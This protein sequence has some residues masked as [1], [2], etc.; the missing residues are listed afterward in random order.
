MSEYIVIFSPELS[1]QP[2]EFATFWNSQPQLQ[3][4]AVVQ[5]QNSQAIATYDMPSW[6][7]GA[8]L[9]IGGMTADIAKDVIT[10][11]LKE[12][13]QSS[14]QRQ[15]EFSVIEKIEDGKTLIIVLPKEEN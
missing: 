14:G 9:F 3:Q 5:V 4:Q 8:L 2:D 1:I 11:V 13:I 6:V 7:V 12:Y 15:P 10:D